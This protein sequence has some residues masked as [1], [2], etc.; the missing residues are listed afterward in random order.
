[1][2]ELFPYTPRKTKF[3]VLEATFVGRHAL[4]DELKKTIRDQATADT[5][6]H[7][8]ILGTRGTG[9]SHIITMI[10]HI[11]RN[12]P[13]YNANWIPVLM[14]EEEQGVFSLPTLFI[15]IVTKLADELEKDNKEKA[16]EIRNY[17]T[18]MR[19]KPNSPETILEDA[20]TC[21]KS[22]SEES[23]KRLLV[24]LENADDLF[25][26]CMP[27]QNEVKKFRKMLQHENYF[28]L[29]ATSPTF[30][31]RIKSRKGVLYDFFRLRRLDLLNYDD[32]VK[33]LQR[34]A[35]KEN[36][37]LVQEF[38]PGNYRL[39]VLYHLTGG[40]P[41][42]L[43]FLFMAISGQERIES[44]VSTFRILLEKDLSNYYL[45]RMRDIPN[46]EQP[47]VIALAET[48][49]V[50]TQTEIASKTFLSPRSVGTFVVR[51]E[52]AGL[53][54]PVSQKKGKNTLYTLTD[55]LFRL[56]YQWRTSLRE[57]EVLEAI[58]EFLSIWYKKK[59]LQVWAGGQGIIA[60][61]AQEALSFRESERFK[62]YLELFQTESQIALDK[63]LATKDYRATFKTID[64]LKEY[65]I[66]TLKM[67][68]SIID[69]VKKC[70]THEDLERLSKALNESNA[71]TT[72]TL[73]EISKVFLG[74]KD[75]RSAEDALTKVVTLDPKNAYAWVNLGDARFKQENFAGAEEA[76]TKA[77]ALD[78]KNV[79][80]LGKLGTV[81]IIQENNAGAEEAMIK[82]LTLDPEKTVGW[83]ILGD[84]R[85][86]QENYA[87]AEEALT[88]AITLDP[89]DAIMWIKL[90]DAR[91]KQEN[92][93]GAEEA[94]IKAVT[95]NPEEARA[96][97]NL[98]L[99]RGRLGN[100]AGAE[101]AYGKAVT[102]NPK[103][104]KA[105]LNLAVANFKNYNFSDYVTN[106]SK[107][108][109][110]KENEYNLFYFSALSEVFLRTGLVPEVFAIVGK[111]IETKDSRTEDRTLLL[112]YR[113]MLFLH[114]GDRSLFKKDLQLAIEL[115]SDLPDESK[116]E[117]QGRLIDFLL[118]VTY[119]DTIDETK[120]YLNTIK[121]FAPEFAFV[122]S[123]MDY[124]VAYFETYH[125]D[126]KD[127]QKSIKRAQELLERIPFELRDLVETMVNK[128]KG[129]IKWW[130]NRPE[131]EKSKRKISAKL[132]TGDIAQGRMKRGRV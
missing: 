106:I 26:K 120:M 7:W 34:W 74:K 21:L 23:G 27:N 36:P 80:G 107:T 47:V 82:A 113:A 119:D 105:W 84:A 4:L 67:E 30:F 118:D 75:F 94:L 81:R 111:N 64:F 128:V 90:G 124:L 86:M 56:W 13:E 20:V 112:L 99:S 48:N 73:L 68:S 69:T 37:S 98:G 52:N 104:T 125:S 5:L 11:V 59:E 131:K 121:E 31:E 97:G 122:F 16:Q 123:P 45:S 129:N 110:L 22:F 14:N 42:I 88:K 114:R 33:L 78:P 91:F 10:Y 12:E 18:G 130:N 95:L 41:R 102:L 55:N 8:M 87:G 32:S 70:E 3:E 62:G 89:K 15:R 38:M 6:Q 25:T 85:F 127:P 96:W 57:K 51:L 126:M 109:E 44:A 61:H 117:V 100:H 83:R 58:V 116:R 77:V 29:I 24:L 92:Y 9:K 19:N 101:E 54:R 2:E 39:R 1:M 66:D 65:G 72:D 60:E 79:E 46:Q 103:N 17:L 76:L 43:M 40:N 132:K 35:E 93:A 115:L 63:Y 108:L 28:L 49:G 50:L 71:I 53:V